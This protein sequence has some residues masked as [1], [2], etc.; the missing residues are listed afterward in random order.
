MI[1]KFVKYLESTNYKLS[2]VVNIIIDG[3]NSPVHL[4]YKSKMNG[5]SEV[6]LFKD[7]EKYFDLSV[8]IPDCDKLDSAEFYLEP[9]LD[10]NIVNQLIKLGLISKTTDTAIAGDKTTFKCSL[11]I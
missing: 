2:G 5:G 9:N 10:P 4:G 1:T 11:N 7:D 3:D 6:A 8:K